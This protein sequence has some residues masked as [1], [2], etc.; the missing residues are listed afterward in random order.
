MKP[1]AHR[2]SFLPFVRWALLALSASLLGCAGLRFGPPSLP[3]G[4]TLAEATRVLGRPTAEHPLPGGARR[5]EYW[6]GT[7]AKST[8][9]VDFDADG[10]LVGMEQ[11]LTEANFY[12]L[13]AGIT[14]DELRA[15]MGPPVST[16]SIGR[17]GIQV[18]NYRYETNDCLW[19]QVS[20]RDAD[21]RV[22]E[23][24]RGMDPACD[25]PN[26]PRP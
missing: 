3:L 12:A 19:F 1:V 18:W 15:R 11:V 14:R 23:T 24:T 20:I 9:M 6:G 16:F 17:Q 10:R 13:P 25:M 2:L 8:Y 21:G 22:A 4:T 7:F 5:L 26:D